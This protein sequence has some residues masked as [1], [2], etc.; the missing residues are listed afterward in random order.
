MEGKGFW[1]REKERG[2]DRVKEGVRG[3]DREN[4]LETLDLVGL[5]TPEAG[6]RG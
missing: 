6:F 4:A 2:M 3:R 1:K 5:K